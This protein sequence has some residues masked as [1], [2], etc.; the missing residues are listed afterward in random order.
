[1]RICGLNLSDS[2]LELLTGS[3]ENGNELSGSIRAGD[4]LTSWVTV[5]F[6]L[7]GVTW[8]VTRLH[9]VGLS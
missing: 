3:C 9:G 2:G 7:Y 5:S 4:F 6:S 1:V 8:L